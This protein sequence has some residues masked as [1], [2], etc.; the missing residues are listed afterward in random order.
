MYKLLFIAVWCKWKYLYISHIQY[1]FG[2]KA[3]KKAD[4]Q[5]AINLLNQ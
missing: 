2:R 3:Y 4:T 1:C 5:R